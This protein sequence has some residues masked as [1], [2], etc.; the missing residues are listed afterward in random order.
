MILEKVLCVVGKDG[1]EGIYE[2]GMTREIIPLINHVHNDIENGQRERHYHGD[3]RFNVPQPHVPKDWHVRS[4]E[5]LRLVIKENGDI[6]DFGGHN[7]LFL[8]EIELYRTDE[9]HGGETDLNLITKSKLKHKCIHK[10]KCPHR[11]FDLSNIKA[12]DGVITCPLHSLQFDE[13]TGKL[14]TDM[15]LI[16]TYNPTPWKDD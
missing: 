15:S 1:R 5:L 2:K 14:L 11:G 3:S 10:G 9:I 4:G 16:K 6:V 7:T 8:E 12:V 13:V